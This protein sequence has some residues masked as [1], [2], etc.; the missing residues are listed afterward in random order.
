[1]KALN[2]LL[3]EDRIPASLV[4]CKTTIDD[5]ETIRQF[6]IKSAFKPFTHFEFFALNPLSFPPD[7]G[8][9]SHLSLFLNAAFHKLT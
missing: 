4:V 9:L 5:E 8:P 3:A 7:Y 6:A 2:S 1:M